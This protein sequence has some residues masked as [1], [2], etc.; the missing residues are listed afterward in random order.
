VTG[1]GW[2][3]TLN[4]VELNS[5][6]PAT[7]GQSVVFK[8]SIFWAH[9]HFTGGAGA[10]SITEYNFKTQLL[11]RYD[12]SAIFRAGT[13]CE[14]GLHVHDG[15]L[16]AMNRGPAANSIRLA[17]LQGGVWSQVHSNTTLGSGSSGTNSHHALFTDSVTGDLIAVPNGGG[18]PGTGTQVWRFE[19]PAGSVI[20]TDITSS[21]LGSV[22]G[23]DKYGV[24]GG[25]ASAARRWSV[26]VDTVT[27][28]EEPHVFLTTWILGGSTEC[29]EWVD[30]IGTNRPTTAAVELEPVG[31]L[32]GISS[33]HA[34]P[35]NSVGGGH[36]TPR[37]A[38][39]EI[40]DTPEEVLAGTKF[41]FRGFGEDS[42][43]TAPSSTLT[44]YGTDTQGT[45]SAVVPIVPGSLSVSA[46]MLTDLEAYWHL[47]D[48]GL[49]ETVNNRDW[50]FTGVEGYNTGLFGNGYE[51]LGADGRYATQVYDAFFNMAQTDLWS[52]QVWVDVDALSNTQA[53]LS[54]GDPTL[55]GGSADGWTLRIGTDG[56]VRFVHHQNGVNHST[57]AGLITAGS[58]MQH[59]VVTND[60][61]TQK[62]YVDSIERAS[63]PSAGSFVG[64]GAGAVLTMG[65]LVAGVGTN[66]LD[67][68]L[69]EVA[70]WSR[71]LTPA[72]VEALYN[73]NSSGGA[74]KE[75][76]EITGLPI[77]PSISGNTI[78][79]FTADNGSTLYSVVLNLDAVNID[80]GDIGTIITDLI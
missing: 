57:P 72:E 54:K 69:D 25:A 61:T 31:G 24:G 18:G 71:R 27:D 35:Y 59:I 3:T 29:W 37:A 64:Q 11:T 22:G 66:P 28:P 62:I 60:G 42:T 48:D 9:Q 43:T 47:N 15:V 12:L 68:V 40:V 70:F 13:A 80:E 1:P 19:D 44:F 75:L 6:Q 39:V 55:G 79:D 41:F 5:A 56:H 8:D 2:G 73:A 23:S 30:Q 67:G 53:L 65:N 76:T 74:G 26:F 52:M 78:T 21:V 50:S 20:A 58:G 77:T 51:V 14:T 38:V 7:V 4:P 63:N 17:K 45:P 34:L 46:G 16:F 33:I 36:R 49:D 32:A 10:G